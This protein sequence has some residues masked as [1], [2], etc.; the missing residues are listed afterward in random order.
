MTRSS[1]RTTTASHMMPMRSCTATSLDT[2]SRTS[3]MARDSDC[4]VCVEIIVHI[5]GRTRDQISSCGK[6]SNF[7]LRSMVPPMNKATSMK[8]EPGLPRNAAIMT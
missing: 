7:R 1:S 8:T 3:T 6:S 4:I 5:T 2:E